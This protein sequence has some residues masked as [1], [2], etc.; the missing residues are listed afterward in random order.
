MA[1]PQPTTAKQQGKCSLFIKECALHKN[2]CSKCHLPSKNNAKYNNDS[3][4]QCKWTSQKK[5]ITRQTKRYH[6]IKAN[7]RAYWK[8]IQPLN[9]N[10]HK[11][12]FNIYLEFSFY[13]FVV[14]ML[15]NTSSNNYNTYNTNH[16][17]NKKKQTQTNKNKHKTN[18]KHNLLHHHSQM[19]IFY[20]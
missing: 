20:T 10:N 2:I 16:T 11:H 8:Q 15:W 1:Q 7:H 17:Q 6:S 12:N 13:F 9:S 5:S 18:K 3:Q 14:A 19:S 4:R